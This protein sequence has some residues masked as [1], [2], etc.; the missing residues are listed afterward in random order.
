ML[1]SFKYYDTNGNGNA[2]TQESMTLLIG[3]AQSLK[4]ESI[5]QLSNPTQH[6]FSFTT[7]IKMASLNTMSLRM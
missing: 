6:Y 7:P 4:L 1:K 5:T 2:L 3:K